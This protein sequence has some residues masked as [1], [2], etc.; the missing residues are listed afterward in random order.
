MAHT[1]I[2]IEIV[3]NPLPVSTSY[4]FMIMCFSC[5]LLQIIPCCLVWH[6]DTSVVEHSDYL[7]ESNYI[8]HLYTVSHTI[9][10]WSFTC[11]FV[12]LANSIKAM[13]SW[14]PRTLTDRDFSRMQR[15]M[16]ALTSSNC[17]PAFVDVP[18]PIDFSSPYRLGANWTSSA[19]TASMLNESKWTIL[20]RPWYTQCSG[21]SRERNS[22]ESCDEL[23]DDFSFSSCSTLF[24]RT[25]ICSSSCCFS[26]KVRGCSTS[27]VLSSPKI[28]FCLDFP[29]GLL[30][31]WGKTLVIAA[32]TFVQLKPLFGNWDV[33]CSCISLNLILLAAGPSLGAGW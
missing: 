15:G 8:F 20:S 27:A 18:F 14:T 5:K 17:V 26:S 1:L 3:K 13:S 32:D 2:H 16:A 24:S 25:R 9:E 23:A 33:S 19:M 30:K 29:T 11:L 12:D 22:H 28:Y 10:V 4:N 7:M 6:T 31:V 21:F